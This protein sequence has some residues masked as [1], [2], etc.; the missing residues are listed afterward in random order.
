MYEPLA[1]ANALAHIIDPMTQQPWVNAKNIQN[2]QFKDGHLSFEVQV[3]YPCQSMHLAVEGTIDVA[4][5]KLPG[6]Q[7]ADAKLKTQIVAHAV[8]TSAQLIKGVK[9]IIAVSSGKGGVG[10]STTAVNLALALAHE[11]ARVG[12]CDADI[13]GPSLPHMLGVNARPELT[14]EKHMIPLRAHGLQ[15]NSIGFLVPPEKATA[16]R[17]PMATGALDQL[18]KQ[19]VWDDL[20]YLVVDMPPGT[21]DI[22]LTLA[23]RVPVTGAVVVTTPQNVALLDAVKGINLFQTTRTPIIGIVE[24]MAVYTCSNCGHPEHIFGKDGGERLAHDSGTGVL[25]HMPLKLAIRQQ[26][27]SGVPTVAQDPESEESRLY[28]DIARKVGAKLALMS[29]DYSNKFPT[30]SI[31]TQS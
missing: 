23:Q 14:A 28:R 31:S 10:K 5:L 29:K 9:N 12:M 3:G 11:G 26:S 27:D 4:L 21:G 30:I 15:V 1:L 25:G 20:D 16:W 22:Q 6:V 18:L 24:N 8:G 19:T 7:V 13:Y 2:L 17:G